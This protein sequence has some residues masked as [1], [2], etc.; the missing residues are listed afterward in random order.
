[1]YVYISKGSVP[2]AFKSIYKLSSKAQ[3]ES[4]MLK[5]LQYRSSKELDLNLQVNT[6]S[7]RLEVHVATSPQLMKSID[8][9]KLHLVTLVSFTRNRVIR[10]L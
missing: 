5:L 2:L 7:C 6:W 9:N 10:L 4:M 8:S 3:F 1:M